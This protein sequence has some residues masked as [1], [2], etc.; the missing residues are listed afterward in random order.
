MVI[1]KTIRG[2]EGHYIMI[3]GSVS[4]EEITILNVYAPN[5]RVSKYVRQKLIELRGEMDKSAIAVGDFTCQ[6]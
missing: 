3:E 2:K 6:W 4:Q 1:Q 5:K